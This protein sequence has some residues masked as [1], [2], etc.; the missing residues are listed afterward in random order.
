M[1]D[2]GDDVADVPLNQL[3]IPA[4]HDMGTFG[5]NSASNDSIDGQAHLCGDDQSGCVRWTAAQNP[6]RN[7]KAQLDEGIRYFDLRVCAATRLDGDPPDPKTFII[8]HGLEAGLL[9]DILTQTRNWIFDHPDEVVILD[10]NHHFGEDLDAEAKMI[11]DIFELPQSE[12][13]IVLPHYCASNNPDSGTCADGITLRSIRAAGRARVIVNF[14]NDLGTNDNQRRNRSGKCWLQSFVLH[15]VSAN[16][17]G[18]L[19]YRAAFREES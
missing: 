17:A 2:L 12:T 19:L 1:T 11:H 10:I 16:H 8:C 15:P 18:R 3:T 5:I 4:T 9:Y 6:S 14:E 13:L 7:A